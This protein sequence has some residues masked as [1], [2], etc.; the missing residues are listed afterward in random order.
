MT[1][2]HDRRTAAGDTDTNGAQ[3]NWGERTA[4]PAWLHEQRAVLIDERVGSGT[5]GYQ[6]C[7]GL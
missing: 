6:A 2:G 7:G 3:G 5:R 1:V 4:G